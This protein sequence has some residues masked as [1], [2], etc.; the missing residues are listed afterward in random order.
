MNKIKMIIFDWDGTLMD[1]TARIVS[2]MQQA[3]IE[4]ELPVPDAEAVRQIIGL[5]LFHAFDVL[6]P[7]SNGAIQQHL[8]Q[9]Y[10]QLYIEEDKTP[11]PLFEGAINCLTSLVEHG[12]SLTVATGKARVGL[13]RVMDEVKLAHLF[14]DTICADEAEGKPSPDMINQLLQRAGL[15]AGQA[16]MIGDTEHDLEMASKAG[17]TSYGVS[18]GAHTVEQLLKWQPLAMVDH[19]DELPHLLIKQPQLGII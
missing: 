6:F 13:T 15:S 8:F 12:F 4:V 14:T 19:L 7:N 9:R 18:H 11:S 1:S 16:V 2:C 10:R 17:V 3:A 5:S